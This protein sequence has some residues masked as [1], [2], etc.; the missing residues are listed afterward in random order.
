ME[1]LDYLQVEYVELRDMVAE[2]RR[3][4]RLVKLQEIF[5]V[6]EERMRNIESASFLEVEECARMIGEL[7]ENAKEA[8]DQTFNVSVAAIERNIVE[9]AVKGFEALI[10]GEIFKELVSGGYKD[11]DTRYF[12]ECEI[13]S[14]LRIFKV[15]SYQSY[16][17]AALQSLLIRPHLTTLVKSC[18]D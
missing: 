1:V 11:E 9:A 10:G 17:Y 15:L 3:M 14:H 8:R 4:E 2:K 7:K 5:K 13:A 12:L 6:V 16:L 18:Y